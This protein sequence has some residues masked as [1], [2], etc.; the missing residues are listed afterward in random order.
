MR[1]CFQH[2]SVSENQPEIT[3]L[4][5]LKFS[6]FF[7]GLESPSS[8]NKFCSFLSCFV[9]LHNL[10][11]Q[12]LPRFIQIFHFL[13]CFT[14]FPDAL[15]QF[16][17][18]AQ[19]RNIE[20]NLASFSE[21]SNIP[22]ALSQIQSASTGPLIFCGRPPMAQIL[23]HE[24]R[25]LGFKNKGH[26]IFLMCYSGPYLEGFRGIPITKFVADPSRDWAF[27]DFSQVWELAEGLPP[28]PAGVLFSNAMKAAGGNPDVFGTLPAWD[29]VWAA[30]HALERARLEMVADMGGWNESEADFLA[31]L[32][33]RPGFLVEKMRETSFV[34]IGGPL[35]WD[36]NGERLIPSPARLVGFVDFF[37]LFFTPTQPHPTSRNQCHRFS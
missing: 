34:G 7:I 14:L 31:W 11:G 5:G 26:S 24:A 28:S 8:S 36:E 9:L 18:Q 22:I 37:C 1:I 30:A 20:Y 6:I 15:E 33:A 19:A 29:A 32:D 13:F 4:P 35:S 12:L 27:E 23:L 17:A 10:S 3:Q 2:N 25:S 21:A 16:S